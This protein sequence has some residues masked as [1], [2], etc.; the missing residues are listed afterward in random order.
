MFN[1]EKSIRHKI[2]LYI[3]SCIGIL[4]SLCAIGLWIFLLYSVLEWY[5]EISSDFFGKTFFGLALP[6]VIGLYAIVK[7]KRDLMLVV[8]VWSFPLS[9]YLFFS[10]IYPILLTSLAYL[11]TA[12][13]MP[14]NQLKPTKSN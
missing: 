10:P 12:I 7:Q 9:L 13:I 8:F 5:D 14:V 4:A 2:R 6:A 3:S 11:I 1:L